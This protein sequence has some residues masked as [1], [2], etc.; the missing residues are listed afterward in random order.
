MISKIFKGND[1]EVKLSELKNKFYT[2]IPTIRKQIYQ[3]VVQE[4]YFEA[5]PETVRTTYGCLG[6][7]VLAVALVGGLIF[8]GTLADYSNA[9]FC[10][11]LGA[12]VAAIGLIILARFMPA[13]HRKGCRG[14]GASASVQTL[15]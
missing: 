7:V 9:V 5:N 4:G 11:P 13:A 12:A 8:V 6:G 14:G 2:A 3:A 15:P 1:R 10:V